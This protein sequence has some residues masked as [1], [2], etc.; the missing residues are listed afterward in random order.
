MKQYLDLARQPGV[1][2]LVGSQL[3]ARFPA[4]M[5]TLALLMH[6]E[7][8]YHS[9]TA[10]GVAIAAMAVAQGVSGPL[11][12]RLLARW[13]MRRVLGTTM[14]LCAASIAA[15]GLMGPWFPAAVVLCTLMGLAVPPISSAVRAMYPSV[16][17]P[18]QVTLL[19][20]VDATL[21]ELIWVLGPLVA[22]AS[23]L[24][25]STGAGLLVAAAITLLG[26]AWFLTSP[27]LSTVRIP[28]SRRRFGVVLGNR[29]VLAMTALNLLM[30]GVFAAIETAVVA[31]F[32]HG[33]V[34]TG[35]IIGLSALGSIAGGVLFGHRAVRPLALVVRLVPILLG[36]VLCCLTQDPFVLGVGFIL[37]GLGCAPV[38]A[39]SFA[40]VSSSVKES[41]TA[42]AYGWMGT[43]QLLGG[44]VSSAFAG[45]AID[46]CGAIGGY[47][48]AVAFAAASLVLAG[49]LGL[50]RVTPDLRGRDATPHPDT[51]PIAVTPGGVGAE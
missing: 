36:A 48:T 23:A 29:V 18:G 10:A 50:F 40:A 49:L 11:T 38:I 22:T 37:A 34:E 17:S 20:S 33:R 51:A 7:Q 14:V 19:F 9:Y 30:I 24:L 13:G 44:A 32:G 31:T 1:A 42:E 21:Q 25:I 27:E 12:S 39:G 46:G 6:L 43:G 8:Q 16:A 45:V 4:G 5:L 28:R 26:G 15:V 35:I 2:R 3:A 47:L 41:Q